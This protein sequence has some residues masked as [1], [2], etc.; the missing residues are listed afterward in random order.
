MTVVPPEERNILCLWGFM[1]TGKTTVGALLAT[2]RAATL[3]DLDDLIVQRAGKSIRR[4]FADEGEAAFRQM[5]RE[6]LDHALREPGPLPRVVALGGG[7]LVNDASRKAALEQAWV[8]TLTASVSTILQRLAADTTRPLLAEDGAKKRT[9]I[10]QLL[11]AR[12]TCYNATHLAI[13]TDDLSAEETAERLS[14]R[15]RPR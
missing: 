4:V 11:M 15:W 13:D 10:E 1:G 8:V 5:E 14:K 3:I 6:A 9:Q 2:Q 7:A 12:A